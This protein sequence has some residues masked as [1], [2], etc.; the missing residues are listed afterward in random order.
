MDIVRGLRGVLKLN[1]FNFDVIRDIRLGNRYFVIDINYF[2]GYAKM[3]VYESV[4]IDFFWDVVSKE[5]GKDVFVNMDMEKGSDEYSEVD[6]VFEGER[7][8][9]DN[10][11]LGR[12]EKGIDDVYNEVDDLVEGEGKLVENFGSECVENEERKLV[13]NFG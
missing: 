11:G 2:F 9:A 4:L 13:G 3:F 5:E 12:V 1:F 6:D 7:K 10:V 8:L